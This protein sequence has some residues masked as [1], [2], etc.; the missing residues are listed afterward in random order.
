MHT[1]IQIRKASITDT[2]LHLVGLIALNPLKALERFRPAFG[3]SAGVQVR[4]VRDMAVRARKLESFSL[5]TGI[6]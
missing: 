3:R 5:S 6:P 4:V 1:T 2:Q